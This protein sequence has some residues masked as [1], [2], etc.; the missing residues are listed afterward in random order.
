M[1]MKLTPTPFN[2]EL[3]DKI[4]NSIKELT[5]NPETQDPRVLLTIECIKQLNVYDRNLMFAYMFICDYSTLE[6][7][8]M[9]GASRQAI[10]GHILELNKQI[11]NYVTTHYKPTL[12]DADN[13]FCN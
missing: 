9:F 4:K 7:S 5:D 1:I 2:N 13:S 11:Q 8:K 6:L 10:K 12:H 3:R